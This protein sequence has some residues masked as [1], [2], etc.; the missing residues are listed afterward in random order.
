M[1]FPFIFQHEPVFVSQLHLDDSREW[2]LP[3]QVYTTQ[4]KAHSAH[5]PKL[6][7][8]AELLFEFP[9]LL[10]YVVYNLTALKMSLALPWV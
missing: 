6:L 10:N 3:H 1:M 5:L 7:A 8:C 4:Q 9:V 2:T